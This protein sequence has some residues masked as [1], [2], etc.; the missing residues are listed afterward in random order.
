VTQHCL[1]VALAMGT[2]AALLPG[3]LAAQEAKHADVVVDLGTLGHDV[4]F[5]VAV[6]DKRQVIG[7]IA[8]NF[9]PFRAPFI[10]ED[11]V[12]RELTAG[13]DLFVL[14]ARDIDDRGRIVGSGADVVTSR[15]VALLWE[16]DGRVIRLPTPPGDLDCGAEAINHRGDVVGTCLT[17]DGADFRFH[18]VL[19]REDTVI[20]LGAAGGG[21]QTVAI[22]INDRGAVLGAFRNPDGSIGGG[23]VWTDG[24]LTRLDPALF[25]ADLNDRGQIAGTTRLSGPFTAFILDRTTIVPLPILA[26]AVGCAGAAI[27]RHAAV[28]GSCILTPVVWVD[29]RVRALPTLSEFAA[30]VN[31]VNDRGDAVG[32]S[33]APSPDNNSRAVLWPSAA[34][35]GRS[36]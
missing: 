10:W 23:F 1:G 18:A 13:P 20:D 24:L 11:G 25:V 4:S 6:N 34:A 9:T 28:G 26:G 5:A 15:G 19:W 30:G 2:A 16:V 27:N 8:D 17:Q 35:H 31:D 33:T 14:D 32:Y 22:A 12:M 21:E 29:G 7:W 36:R 3:A